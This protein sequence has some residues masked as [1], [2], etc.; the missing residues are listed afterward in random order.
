LHSEELTPVAAA[1]VRTSYDGFW[2][3]DHYPVT[4]ILKIER[5]P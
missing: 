3:S 2:P 5:T 1:I 4:A